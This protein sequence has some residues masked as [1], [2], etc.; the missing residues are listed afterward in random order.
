MTSTTPRHPPPRDLCIES[1]ILFLRQLL[2]APDGIAALTSA[3]APYD[4]KPFRDGGRWRGDVPKALMRRGIIEPVTAD[5]CAV[6]SAAQRPS[7]NRTIL[8]RWRLIDRSAA[9][10]RLAELTACRKRPADPSL[11]DGYDD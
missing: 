11:F 3:P 4:K 6:A 8:R 2:A 9:K 10:R 7:R 1:E 5:D